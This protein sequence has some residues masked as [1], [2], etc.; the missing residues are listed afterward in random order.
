MPAVAAAAV[1]AATVK[2]A[3]AARLNTIYY[4]SNVSRVVVDPPALI[5]STRPAEVTGA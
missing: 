2:F 5:T 3:D 4:T 1:A